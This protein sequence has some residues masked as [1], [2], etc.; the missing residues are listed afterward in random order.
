ML[1]KTILT[2]ILLISITVNSQTDNSKINEQPYI[3]ATGTAEKEI[4]PDIIHI[5]ILLKDKSVNKDNYTIIQQEDKLLKSLK[6]VNID[7][8]N[9]ALSNAT[10]ELII[11]KQKEKGVEEKK[12]YI[13]LLNSADEVSK[14]FNLLQDINIKE[15]YISYRSHTQIDAYQKEVRINAIKAA[16]DKVTYLL[17]AIGEIPGKPLVIQEYANVP[18]NK[19]SN[20]AISSSEDDNSSL[21]NFKKIKIKSSYYVKY[22]IK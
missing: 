18:S 4:V 14:V 2:V 9:L 22:S 11:S 16:K 17:Q 5:T 7:L 13:L 15:A 8:K 12:E 1:S 6:S 20:V 19:Y 3:E 21:V 10:S